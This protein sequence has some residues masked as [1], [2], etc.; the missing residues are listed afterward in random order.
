MEDYV[1]LVRSI[2]SMVL[3]RTPRDR[4]LGNEDKGYFASRNSSRQH[5]GA[6]Y[7]RGQA[8]RHV[9]HSKVLLASLASL[10]RLGFSPMFVHQGLGA[11]R[12]L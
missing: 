5:D 11:P 7:G 9:R 6:N 3:N 12:K 1:V 8:E 2:I 4:P 10:S